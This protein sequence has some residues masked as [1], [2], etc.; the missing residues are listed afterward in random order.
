MNRIF[1]SLLLIFVGAW[2][3]LSNLQLVNFKFQRD[4]PIILILIGLYEI[5][6]GVRRRRT[7]RKIISKEKIL[8]ELEEGKINV[9][10][11]L[12]KLKEVG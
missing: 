8:K 4:W 9:E 1:W 11:A 12:K 5:L 6:K 3:W 7:K 10:E 2:I